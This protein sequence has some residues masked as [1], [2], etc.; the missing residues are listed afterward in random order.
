MLSHGNKN[1]EFLEKIFFLAMNRFFSWLTSC[2]T[3]EA[4]V[5]TVTAQRMVTVILHSQLIASQNDTAN[6]ANYSI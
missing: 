4:S 6:L 3:K 2:R 5:G 1:C